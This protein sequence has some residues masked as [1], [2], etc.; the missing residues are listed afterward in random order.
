MRKLAAICVAAVT[1]ASCAQQSVTDLGGGRLRLEY[2]EP[3]AQ[4]HSAASIFDWKLRDLCPKGYTK[5][6]D[7]VETRGNDR[8][9][10]WEVVCTP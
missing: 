8:W 1:L 2:T 10:V 4:P 3:L 6:K 7:A 9:Y 5:T